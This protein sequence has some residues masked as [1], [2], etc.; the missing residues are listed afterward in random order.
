M[1]L[2]Q[3]HIDM[4]PCPS[5][6]ELK[7]NSNL[8]FG[9]TSP[10]G[11]QVR[12]NEGSYELWL[13]YIN[14]RKQLDHRLAAYD[15]AF[16]AL[17][18]DASS[19]QKDV[20]HS[21]ACIL[22]L[23]LLMMDCLCISGNSE[24]A[25][26]TIYRFLPA[27]TNSDGPHPPMFT[28]I[29]TCLTISDKCVLWVS[30]IYLVIYRKLPD[31]VVLQLER[32]KELLPVEWPSVHLD[33]DEKKRVVQ[34]LETV[35]CCV[36]SYINTESFKS[37]IDLRSAQLFALNHIKCLVAINS[38]ECC[39]DLL[40]KYSKVYPSCLELVLISARV[41]KYDSE[42]LGFIGFEE[43]LH[44]WPK[45]ASGIHCIWN[46]YAEYAQQNGKSDLVKKLM[47]RWYHS[48]WK[49][50][51]PESENLNALE[52][53][54]SVSVELGSTSKPD[55]L[56]PTSHQMDVMFGYL[57]LFLYN[58]LQNDH[59]EAC[60]AIDKAL[61]VAPPLGFNHCAREHAL[62]LL[63][64]ESQKEGVPISWQLSTLNM[65]FDIARSFSVSEP[66]SRRFI[67]KI[68]KSRVQQLVRNILSPL[69]SDSSLVNMVLEVWYG[70][71]LLPQ[72]LTETKDLVDFVEAILVIAPSNYELVFSVCKML[73]RG[74]SYRDVAPSLL[75]WA[76]ST[77]VNALF[78][79]IPIPPE[80]VLVE[81]ADILDSIPDTEAIRKR[82]YMKALTVYPF[83]L[84]LWRSYHN[85]T[86]I[87]GDGNI[88]AEAAR[89]RGIELD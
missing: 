61:R 40:D 58:F 54:N 77:L 36:D 10:L 42:N 22:D 84:K 44:N 32:E 19:C 33:N 43:A 28:D 9:N 29:L 8:L 35:A 86:K 5:F 45:E 68:E 85:V 25:I 11:L 76:S 20:M 78:H 21:S 23:F 83:S 75:F 17:C 53:G 18:R 46:Q 67:S 41:Q 79:A 82:F 15:A 57:N 59:V 88:V 27:T 81:A 74:D 51:Y 47:T 64:D 72:N 89:E 7:R 73:S 6:R 65:Y 50:K 60:S 26:Q 55:F 71:S 2:I 14:S 49:V 38:T 56:V 3:K 12:N 80:F 70:P 30:C 37:D 87:K 31:A 24:K 39:Q 66:L 62:F 34:L 48:V 63:K 52:G 1:H 69:S 16:S 13:M 4:H